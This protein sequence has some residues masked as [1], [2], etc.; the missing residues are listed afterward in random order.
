M[1]E[2]RP[3][4]PQLPDE[5]TPKD[6]APAA[7][8]EL[9]TLSK[10]NAERV[11][12]HLAMAAQLI[13]DDPALA[14]EHALAASRHAGRIPVARETVA[15]TAYALGDYAL[16]L[17]ELRTY[18]RLSGREDQIALMVDSERGVGRPERALEV[19]R[20][21]ERSTLPADVRVQLAIAMSGAWL[22]QGDAS[23]ALQELEI[24]EADPDHAY[25]WSPALFAARATVLEEL[26]RTDEATRWQRLADVA[27]DALDEASGV[28]QDETVYVEDLEEDLDE[29]GEDP[30]ADAAD[31]DA[32]AVPDDQAEA[33]D[34]EDADDQTEVEPQD[35]DLAADETEDRAGTISADGGQSRRT[36]DNLG[37]PRTTSA[38]GGQ[39]RRT[40]DNLGG[41]GTTSAEGD[42]E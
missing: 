41:P 10:E 3:R 29:A 5:I 19:G 18:R 20:S 7:R 42:G 27:A 30:P 40:G 21:V 35:D 22:D 26:G 37:G 12:R 17:R 39:S 14:H 24:P 6:L 15:I 13:D 4:D 23:R 8:N 9:K 31:A 16:A 33:G 11:A 2:D 28:G 1:R 36:E 38:D 34:R 25:E 32:H